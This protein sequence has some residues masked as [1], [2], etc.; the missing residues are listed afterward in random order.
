LPKAGAI[1]V[2]EN[3]AVIRSLVNIINQVDIPPAEVVSEFI[4]LERADAGKV[5]DMLKEVFDRGTRA[6]AAILRRASARSVRRRTS[7][8][9]RSRS[10]RYNT[11]AAT[12]V[13]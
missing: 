5:V 2:T 9:C 7:R 6:P 8:K 10:S 1:L 13:G 12:L 3:S 4:K 11:T